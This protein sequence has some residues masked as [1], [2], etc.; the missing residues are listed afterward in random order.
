MKA[1]LEA[2]SEHPAGSVIGNATF[3]S[4]EAGNSLTVPVVL[5]DP[6][7]L[8][9]GEEGDKNRDLAKRQ[10]LLGSCLSI[11]GTSSSCAVTYCW[12]KKRR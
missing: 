4:E 1:N 3:G 2:N 11:F 10:S 5:V 9:E 12:R 8:L 7:W 6:E